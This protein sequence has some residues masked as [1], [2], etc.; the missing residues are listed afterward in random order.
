MDDIWEAARE[1]DVGEVERLVRHDPGLLNAEGFDRRTPLMLASWEGHVGVV[2]WLVDNGA[3][4]HDRDA[5]GST[6]LRL[7]CYHG[8]LDVTRL[9]FEKGADPTLGNT[10]GG[11]PL[12]AASSNGHLEVVRFLLGLPSA[13]ASINRRDS[14]G[15]TTHTAGRRC[16]RPAPTAAG[17]WRGRS[18]RAGPTQPS[19]AT[20]TPPPWPSPRRMT[21]TRVSSSAAASACRCWR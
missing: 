3:A 2:R 18:W 13:K 14:L 6:A 5:Y 21:P 12:I 10:G 8:R 17:A 19:Q 9:L 20:T 7:A 1:G 16:M 15:R 11:T 4:I